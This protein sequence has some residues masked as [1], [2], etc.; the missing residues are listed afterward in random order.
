MDERQPYVFEVDD[1]TDADV[2]AVLEDWMDP[3]GMALA[4]LQETHFFTHKQ[5]RQHHHLP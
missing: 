3:L 2:V 1:E 4:N 5:K